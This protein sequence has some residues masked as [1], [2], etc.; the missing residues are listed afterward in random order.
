MA[1]LKAELFHA[2][3]GR[4]GLKLRERMLSSVDL[5]GKFG[6]TLPAVS[7]FFLASRSMRHIFGKLFGFATERPLPPFASKTV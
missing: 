2:R 3:I 6:C 4:D 5:L 1:L 7:N